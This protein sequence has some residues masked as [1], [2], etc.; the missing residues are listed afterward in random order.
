MKMQ[1]KIKQAMNE[2]STKEQDRR[3]EKEEMSK[4][5]NRKNKHMG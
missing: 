3:K 1:W 5:P 4:G 2:I